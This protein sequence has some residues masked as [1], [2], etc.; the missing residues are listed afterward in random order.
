VEALPGGEGGG[1]LVRI[2]LVMEDE[3]RHA[4]IVP[5]GRPR[6]IG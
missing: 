3:D 1:A 2:V 6:N 4:P 5:R